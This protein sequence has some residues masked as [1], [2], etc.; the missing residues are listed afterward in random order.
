V[1]L[2]AGKRVAEGTLAELRAQANLQDG[3]LE[4]I[5]LALT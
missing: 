1:L 2:N 5:F 4:E 3:G